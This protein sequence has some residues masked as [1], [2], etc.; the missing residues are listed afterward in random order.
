MKY[1]AILFD[2]DGTLLDTLE[3]MADALEQAAQLRLEEDDQ[4]DQTELHRAA[5]EAVDHR[6]V[7]DAGETERNEDEQHAAGQMEGIGPPDEHD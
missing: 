5:Q 7:H 6:E 3:D 4:R 2:L 1:K